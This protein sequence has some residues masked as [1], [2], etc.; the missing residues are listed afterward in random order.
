VVVVWCGGGV[1]PHVKRNFSKKLKIDA[2][3]LMLMLM[4]G[5][6]GATQLSFII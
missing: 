2:V 1:T 5:I 4:L 3:K 6:M